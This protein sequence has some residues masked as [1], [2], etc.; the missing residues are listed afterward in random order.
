MMW[1]NSQR[2][3]VTHTLQLVWA[4]RNLVHRRWHLAPHEAS[5]VAAAVERRQAGEGTTATPDALTLPP[6]PPADC[7]ASLAV[8]HH[9]PHSGGG[10]PA[11]GGNGNAPQHAKAQQVQTTA[12]TPVRQAASPADCSGG[13]SAPASPEVVICS[14]GAAGDETAPPRRK[15]GRPRKAAQTAQPGAKGSGAAQPVAEGEGGLSKRARSEA[16]PADQESRPGSGQRGSSCSGAGNSNGD[17]GGGGS[18]KEISMTFELVTLLGVCFSSLF[19]RS[20]RIADC[21]LSLEA[22]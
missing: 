22:G 8:M 4:C 12:L 1:P 5:A 2:L 16:Q 15:R 3:S 7:A 20:M 21:G 6:P 13:S 19:L 10:Y 11:S 9:R 18:G 17:G 14:E